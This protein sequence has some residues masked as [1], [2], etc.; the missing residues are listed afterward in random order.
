ME[1]RRKSIDTILCEAVEIASATERQAYLDRECGDDAELRRQAEKLIADYF[2]AGDFL[3]DPV[4]VVRVPNDEAPQT[5]DFV[6][7]LDERSA[8]ERPTG[9]W[10][11]GGDTQSGRGQSSAK[12]PKLSRSF[13]DYE[14]LQ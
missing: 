8:D 9:A 13:G 1:P 11:E 5:V 10:G 12:G 2:E 6:G 7:C 4:A 3:L 14:L